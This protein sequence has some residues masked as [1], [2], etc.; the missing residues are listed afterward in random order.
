MNVTTLGQLS[1]VED[2]FKLIVFIL[3]FLINF[4]FWGHWLYHFAQVMVRNHFTKLQKACSCFGIKLESKVDSY[5]M[6]LERELD[7]LRLQRQEEEKAKAEIE[8]CFKERQ[9]K[10]AERKAEKLMQEYKS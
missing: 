8:M 5:E 7:R 10:E 4:A 1:E 9:R 6:D 3:V 2:T